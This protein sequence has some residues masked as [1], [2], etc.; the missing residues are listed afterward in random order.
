MKNSVV[1]MSCMLACGAILTPIS[2][3][4]GQ[5]AVASEAKTRDTRAAEELLARPVSVSVTRVSLERA[6]DAVAASAKVPLQYES[7]TIEAYTTPVTI[8]VTNVALRA[9]LE[10]LLAGTS[11]TAV[12]DAESRIVLVEA[13]AAS[14]RASTDGGVKGIVVDGTTKRPVVGAAVTLDS[15][16]AIRTRDNGTFAFSGVPA[17]LHRVV[18]RA[19]GYRA[20]TTPVTVRDGETEMITVT[21]S[22]SSTTLTEVVTTAT[23]D[24][25]RLE[26]G[27]AVGTIKAD[28][29]VATSLIRN[30]SDLLQ[31]SVPGVVVSNTDGAVG[32][33]S[34]IRLRGVN[35]IALN[36]DPIIILDGVRLNAQST[37]ASVETNVG[38]QQMLSR[39]GQGPMKT[40][41]TLAPSRL[42]DI[43]P[44]TIESIDVL[45]GP[46]ASSLY[47]TDAANGVIIIKTK[48]GQAGSWRT[49]L[50]GDLGTSSIPGDMPEMWWGWGSQ[51][52]I[53]TIPNCALAAGLAPTVLGGSCQQDSVTQFNPQNDPAMRTLGTG[54]NRSLSATLSGGTGSLQQFF[55]ANVENNV[56]MAKMSDAERRII[57]RLWSA[58]APSWMVRPNT[59]QDIDGSSRTTFN[60]TPQADVSLTSNVI[61]R[62]VLNGGSGL[63]QVGQGMGAS[64]S[65]T[66]G[67]LPSDNQRT[68]ITSIAKRGLLSSNASY[69]PMSWLSISGTAGGDYTL[70]TDGSDLRAQDCTIAVQ[71]SRSGTTGCPSGHAIAQGQTFVTTVNGGAQLSFRPM[72]WLTLQTSLGE[73]Y[74]HTSFYNMQI[75]NNNGCSLAFGTT[76]FTPT[77]VCRTSSQQV[78]S[79]TEARDEAATAGWYIEET[80]NM[81]GMFTTF[82]V[83]QDVAS[84]FG[85]QVTKSPPNYPKLNLSY[86]LSEQSFFPKQSFVSS[87]RLRVAY[88]Q[89]GNQASQTAVR[90]NFTQTQATFTGASSGSQSVVLSQPGNPNLQPEKGT[91]WEG[92][93]DVSFLDNERVHAEVTFYRKYTRNAIT[94]L[95][96][97]PSYGTDVLSQYVNLGNVQNRGLELSLTS[98]LIDTRAVAWSLTLN[99][100]QNANKLVHKASGLDVNGPLN[101]QFVEGYPLF[102]FWGA[103]VESYND[104]NQDSILA[105]SE[106][107]FGSPTFMGA[108][109]PKREVTYQSGITFLNG[110]FGVSADLDQIVGQTTPLTLGSNG[111]TGILPR[112]A[113]DRS[114]PLAAQAAYVQATLNNNAY[115]LRTSSV[116]LNKLSVI[117]NVPAT[118]SQ[119]LFH[120]H[121]ASL[122]LAA[123]NLALWS[124][125]AGKDPNVDTS[126]LF[127]DATQDN[128]LGTPQPR[129]FTF[130]FNLGL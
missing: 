33:P 68:K 46:S 28:S 114:A 60:V 10:R 82:G 59:E 4:L 110:M 107:K 112:A 70:R 117:Y 23:G 97:A 65:D 72:S 50:M 1:W 111:T 17:G 16:R 53:L 63:Q 85:G 18:V 64:P 109:Y 88:G 58:P 86:P 2:W 79:V 106:I 55:S 128:G 54:T 96:L 87:L 89:S 93:F 80:V 77:P 48:K 76:L 35:S 105:P 62:N 71:V 49:T 24:R 30:V 130:R 122:T 104:L 40:A 20:S 25:R 15:G 108:P 14:G 115:I 27:N 3:I 9:V 121:S 13:S 66:L 56:G 99:L 78:F 45:R 12:V 41:S 22:A 125:Y 102:G 84:A 34:K 38:A 90:N 73:Q 83:R 39:Q 47:G 36:N 42:D 127:G 52:A 126:G 103:P 61:Y 113:V 124:N 123:R 67:F 92:G 6:I 101:T 57:A 7:R 43:D 119:R 29:V 31:A 19:L 81:L 51:A 94:L 120:V 75:G 21:L 100:T 44:N 37:G 11:L 69:R 8:H 26:V 98:K 5:T 95:P 32:S 74:S 91:E 116:R 118:L 129:M